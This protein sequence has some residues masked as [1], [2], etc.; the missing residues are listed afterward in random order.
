MAA[1]YSTGAKEVAAKMRLTA[2]RF[3][4][5]AIRAVENFEIIEMNEMQK[6]V[7]FDTGE[8][9]N[10]GYI[11]KPVWNGNRISAEMGFRAAHAMV[12]HEDLEAFHP[13]GQA[14]YMESVLNESEPFFAARCADDI[15]SDLGI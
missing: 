9:S 12:V 14:K 6:R 7:P 8:L 3:R 13:I 15:K 1:P 10:S 4:A 2:E 5:S 11:T